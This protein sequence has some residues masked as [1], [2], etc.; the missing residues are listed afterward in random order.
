MSVFS[1]TWKWRGIMPGVNP[2]TSKNTGMGTFF[3][4]CV[5]VSNGPPPSI[6][7]KMKI[8]WSPP[9]T[10]P[11]KGTGRDSAARCQGT[12]GR[13]QPPPQDTSSCLAESIGGQY[14]IRPE[15]R[16][17]IPHQ[18]TPPPPRT[19]LQAGIGLI[20]NTMSQT[21]GGWRPYI[22]ER[23]FGFLYPLCSNVLH[24]LL[25]PNLYIYRNLPSIK[26]PNYILLY[27][28][29]LMPSFMFLVYISGFG[30]AHHLSVTQK[31]FKKNL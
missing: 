25:G 17:S 30:K 7:K 11:A 28:T 10:P 12:Y 23:G 26:Y 15:Q 4:L 24:M 31:M 21:S 6:A 2:N 13:H 19:K 1:H 27:N 3:F 8:H 14:M 29:I 22:L 16:T 18:L 20:R 5:S 9:H